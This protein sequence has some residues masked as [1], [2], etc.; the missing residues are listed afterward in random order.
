MIKYF[1]DLCGK[2]AMESAPNLRVDFLD[3]SWH[4]AKPIAGTPSVV[5]G[6]W[7]PSIE[8]QVVFQAH[9]FQHNKRPHCPDIRA[10]CAASLLLKMSIQL[11]AIKQE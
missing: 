8:A 6:W 10:G 5:D 9:D 11:E 2:P 4:G 1:C 3:K 7:T